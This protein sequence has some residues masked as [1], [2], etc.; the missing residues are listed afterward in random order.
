MSRMK[1]KIGLIILAAGESSRMGRS[2][3]LL[4]M[5]DSKLLVNRILDVVKKIE[6]ID[7]IL[8]LG[9]HKN[10]ILGAICSEGITIVFNP[11]WQSGM[12]GSISAGVNTASKT[13][14][15]G[16][17]ISVVDQPFLDKRVFS[18]MLEEIDIEKEQI[19]VSK[20]DEGSGPPSFFHRSYFREL[21]ELKGDIGA[22]P[23]V[24]KYLDKVQY[25]DFEKGSFDLDTIEDFYNYRN[26]IKYHKE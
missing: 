26:I 12:G 25:V 2:K 9:A 7:P 19:I 18:K 6:G 24:K 10:D 23:I 1:H 16:V 17:I 4:R 3:Q 14:C 15:D 11:D 8:V 20:Y 21:M 13:G 22:K 5:E